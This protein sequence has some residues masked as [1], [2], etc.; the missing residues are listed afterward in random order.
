MV[1]GKKHNAYIGLGSNL[2]RRKKNITA[3][4]GAL[5]TTREIEI[6]KVSSLYETEPLGGPDDQPKFINAVAHV[7]TTLSPER[8]LA[9][10]FHIEDSLGR[11]RA[12]RWGRRTIDLDL[13]IYEQE[14]RAT[15]DLTLPHPMMHER[16]FVM[17]PLAE[18]APDLMHP[19]LE[20][21]AREILET[22]PRG[23]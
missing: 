6:V 1:K 8:L 22:L 13:L 21:T 19:T 17:E 10:C 3:A 7:R 5:E 15:P 20:Q 2:G 18:V 4:L 23:S 11:K 12:I 16:W 14:I 9:V